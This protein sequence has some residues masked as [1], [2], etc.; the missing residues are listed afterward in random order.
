MM[1]MER[2][3]IDV[4]V[5]GLCTQRERGEAAGECVFRSFY[6][7]IFPSHTRHTAFPPPDHVQM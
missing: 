5:R 2:D 3:G 1:E 6:A 4:G 7:F